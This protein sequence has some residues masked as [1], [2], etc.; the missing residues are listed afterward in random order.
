[1]LDRDDLSENSLITF[2]INVFIL[3]KLFIFSRNYTCKYLVINLVFRPYNNYSLVLHYEDLPLA[4]RRRQ[5]NGIHFQLLRFKM[6][7]WYK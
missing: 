1:M 2:E 4:S 6:Y 3:I 7:T 5:S